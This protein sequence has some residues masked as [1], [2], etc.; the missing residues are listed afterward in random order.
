MKKLIAG[1][2]ALGL[3]ITFVGCGT[4]NG[5]GSACY[6]LGKGVATDFKSMWNATQKA[7]AWIKNKAW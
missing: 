3:L 6:S 4:F 7:D 5:I 2:V 1:L